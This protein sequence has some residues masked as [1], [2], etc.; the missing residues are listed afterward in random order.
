[1]TFIV[2]ADVMLAWSTL[3]N[4]AVLCIASKVLNVS[5]RIKHALLWSILTSITTTAEY[6]LTI[7]QNTL[8]YHILYAGIYIIMTALYFEVH[9]LKSILFN[10]AVI[11]ICMTVIYG[12]INALGRGIHN[13]LYKSSL[14]LIF[15]FIPLLTVIGLLKSRT[16]LTKNQHKLLINVEDKFVATTGYMDSG[17]LLVDSC[18]GYPVIVLDYRIMNELL[19]HDAYKYILKYH[20]TGDFNYFELDKTCNLRFYPIP[21]K[22]ISSEFAIMPAFKLTSLTYTDI[23]ETFLQVVAGISRYKLRNKDDYQVLLNES[24]KPNREEYSND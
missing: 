22:T 4:F 8:I 21:Y 9:T 5:I 15:S 18:T 2:Y 1:M 14:I 23:G 20:T 3:I 16:S 19:N 7:N 11:L 12:I 13:S 24:L 6:L 17:N 10:A